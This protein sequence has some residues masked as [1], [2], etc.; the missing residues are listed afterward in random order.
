MSCSGC[1]T[2]SLGGAEQ[3][4]L[5]SQIQYALYAK[6]LQVARQE[7]TAVMALLESALNLAKEAGL[8]DELDV[9]A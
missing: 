9:H 1:S 4:A 6:H 5:S 8:G 2:A 7:G 3:A